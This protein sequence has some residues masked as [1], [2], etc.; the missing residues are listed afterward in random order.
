MIFIAFIEFLLH[1]F[2]FCKKS[3]SI[4]DQGRYIILL[5]KHCFFLLR[6]GGSVSGASFSIVFL[7]FHTKMVPLSCISFIFHQNDCFSNIKTTFSLIFHCISIDFHLFLLNFY[8]ICS[9]S[10][11]IQYR[12]LI[13]A[14][15]E[16]YY[17]KI[18]FFLFR[19][20]GSVSGASFSFSYVN[21]TKSLFFH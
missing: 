6:L 11:K 9:I 14:A 16:F 10:V 12:F 15:I 5:H 13:K 3:G 2:N 20:G 18:V 17:T 19:L 7:H 8:W 1:L 4:F 21:D